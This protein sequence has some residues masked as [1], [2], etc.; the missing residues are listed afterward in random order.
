MLIKCCAAKEAEEDDDM[1]G[2]DG[3]SF[4]GGAALRV[5]DANETSLV[6]GVRSAWSLTCSKN[7]EQ[8]LDYMAIMPSR[9]HRSN[10]VLCV[11]P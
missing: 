1:C 9:S 6:F 2:S 8:G 3:V 7:Q 5:S 11:T 10:E 4:Q